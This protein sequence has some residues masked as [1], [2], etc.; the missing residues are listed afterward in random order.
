MLTQTKKSPL[1]RSTRPSMLLLLHTL[2]EVDTLSS[3]ATVGD[4]VNSLGAVAPEGQNVDLHSLV[5]AGELQLSS[6][7]N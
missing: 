7:V 5:L 2:V 3:V 1:V 4:D 6:I